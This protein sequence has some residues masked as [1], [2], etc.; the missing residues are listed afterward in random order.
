M[1]PVDVVYYD[2]AHNA[3]S[4]DNFNAVKYMSSHAKRNY[5]FTA[6]PKYSIDYASD[7]SGMNNI[8]VYG[9]VI[10]RVDFNYLLKQG[11]I[12]K[13]KL[14]LLESD[15]DLNNQR[16]VDVNMKTIVEVVD[17]YETKYVVS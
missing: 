16:Q 1:I 10:S 7:L 12:V 13:P 4:S 11:V 14:H 3:T 8:D 9:D 5:F 6:T 17:H 15:A 2:E